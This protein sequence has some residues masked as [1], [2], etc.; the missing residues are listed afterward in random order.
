[1][2]QKFEI[3][4]L[5]TY[6]RFGFSSINNTKLNVMKLKHK[7]GEDKFIH[8]ILNIERL[9]K[10]V[11]YSN[12]FYNL[13]KYGFFSLS[14]CGLCKL[15]MHIRTLIYCLENKIG[16]VCDGANKNMKLF[17]AQMPE[18]IAEL[19]GMYSQYGITYFTPV[20]E[21]DSPKD[22]GWFNKLGVEKLDILNNNAR[23]KKSLTSGKI[24]FKM[25]IL[26][27]ENVKGT[28]LDKKMQFRCFQ[29]ILFNI[30]VNWHFIPTYGIQKYKQTCISFYREKIEYFK[31]FLEEYLDKR[32]QSKLYKYLY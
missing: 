5:I 24:L 20:F 15:T 8:D 27:E 32:N 31:S 17:P 11:S 14:T 13:R 6:Q 2:G 12:Y 4:H 18:V 16:Y 21:F 29:F 19:K 23:S 28:K 10:K 3:V 7:F 30:F 26:P 25:G 22:I 1:M 9:F